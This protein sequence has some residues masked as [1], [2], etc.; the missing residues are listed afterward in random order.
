[1]PKPKKLSSSSRM[2]SNAPRSGAARI[3]DKVD[4]SKLCKDDYVAPNKPVL[5]DLKPATYLAISGQGAPGGPEFTAKVGALYAVAYTVKMTRK[6]GGKQDYTIGKLEAQWWA[7]DPKACFASLPKE[8]WCW[9]LL[10]RTPD[11]VQPAELAGAVA[12]LAKKGKAPEAAQVALES[13]SEGRCVQ[14]LH[15]GPYN[16]E[17]DTVAR[18]DTFA[19]SQDLA[20]HGLHHEI[21]ISD[22]RRVPPDRLKTVLRQP[23]VKAGATAPG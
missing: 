3:A 10:I 2:R 7:L 18:M 19:R 8:Q 14:M 12:A 4:L 11:F 22:P 9:K 16:R 21:Y 5:L 15:I 13:L 23:V 17:G 1:M 6:F 20:F